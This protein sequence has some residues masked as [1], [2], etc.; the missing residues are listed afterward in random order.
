MSLKDLKI[1]TNI[2]KRIHSES[3]SYATELEY[4]QKRIDKFIEENR[5]EYDIKKQKEV[6]EETLKM[7]P[8]CKNRLQK[9]YQELQ[10]LVNINNPSWEG[11]DELAKA[12]ETLE[13][14]KF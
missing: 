13:T 3:K 10:N 14:V 6:L 1:K 5:D 12:K 9:A 2:V 4:Q 11:T 8:D 7:I